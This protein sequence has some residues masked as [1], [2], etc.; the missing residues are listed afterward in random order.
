MQIVFDMGATHTRVS[1]S[2]DG[3]TLSDPLIFNTEPEFEPGIARLIDTIK[4]LAR[5]DQITQIAGGVP[6]ALSLDN[7]T[8]IG[9]INH[10]DWLKQ[11][12]QKRLEEAFNK[13]VLLRNDVAMIGLGEDLV[14]AG[15]DKSIVV[16]MTVSTGV[17]GVRVV[18]GRLD[19]TVWNTEIGEQII[20]ADDNGHPINLE[21]CT[22]G[23]ALQQHYGKTA[24]ELASDSAVWNQV[25]RN[26]AIGVHNT[27]LYW[28][29]EVIVF[30]GSMLRDIPLERLSAEV[31]SL[32]TAYPTIP[33]FR[34]AKL[35]DMGGLYGGLA[36]LRTLT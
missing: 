30:G 32:M 23:Q 27:I 4:H 13:P 31:K 21:D 7:S 29:P 17:N 6:A 18:D 5:Q 22:G 36:L 1:R 26:L 25:I 33:E 20:G 19:K 24:P 14:G 11:P 3:E 12:F 34:P 28:S 9:A 15:K 16:Y 2:D 8:V 35:G 10:P